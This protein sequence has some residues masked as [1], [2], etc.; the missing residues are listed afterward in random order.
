MKIKLAISTNVPKVCFQALFSD[1]ELGRPVGY[2]LVAD[3]EKHPVRADGVI[4]FLF[5]VEGEKAGVFAAAR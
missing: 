3:R 4:E 2:A 5:H 1:N